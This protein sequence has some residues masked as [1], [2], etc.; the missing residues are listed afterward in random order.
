MQ[1]TLYKGKFKDGKIALAKS[2]TSYYV[3]WETADNLGQVKFG[4]LGPAASLIRS[5]Q[6]S[7]LFKVHTKTI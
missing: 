1:K 6:K 7:D 4:E 3:V 2:G 5:I